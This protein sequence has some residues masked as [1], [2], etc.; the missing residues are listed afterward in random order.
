MFVIVVVTGNSGTPSRT[1]NMDNGGMKIQ[2]LLPLIRCKATDDQVFCLPI[3]RQ[4][5]V[6][7]Y[8]YEV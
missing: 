2:L 1:G 7:Y 5:T 3:L 8:P 4:M 6:F